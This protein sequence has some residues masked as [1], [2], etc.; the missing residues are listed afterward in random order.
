M[1]KAGMGAS[2]SFCRGSGSRKIPETPVQQKSRL[3]S[4]DLCEGM[5]YALAS[6]K[7]NC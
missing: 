7:T 6:S 3:T 2:T 4:N 5:H 1:F